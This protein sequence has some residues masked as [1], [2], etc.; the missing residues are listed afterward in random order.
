[1]TTSAGLRLLRDPG[2]PRRATFLELFFDLVFVVALALISH[3]L[4]DHF[5]LAGIAQA[6]VMLL[7]IWWVWSITTLVTDFYDPRRPMIQAVTIGTMFGVLLMA[8]AV[9]AA[10]TDRGL[11]FA[12]TYVAI[13]LGRGAL[14]VP[15][16]LGEPVRR[17]AA[18]VAFWFAVSAVPWLIGAFADGNVRLLW[19]SAALVIDYGASAFSYPVPVAGRLPTSQFRVTA[20]HLSERYQQFFILALGDIILVA[21]TTFSISGF[22]IGSAAAFTVA[23]ASAA[24]LWRIYVH[25]AGELLPEAIALSTESGRFARSAP[26]THVVMIAG[27]VATAASAKIT[28]THPTGDTQAGWIAIILGGPA[29]FLAGRARFESEVL[30]RTSRPLLV[31]LAGIAAVAPLMLLLPPVLIAV[32]ANLAL[33]GI[34]GHDIATGHRHPPVSAAPD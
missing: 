4:V 22:S 2:S 30:G 5:G 7:A 23:F 16:L 14:L 34:V 9:P 12:G 1:M 6:I 10:F 25:Q 13:H 26:Y 29:L 32:T 18:Q 19:W 24:L 3:T 21:G 27:V 31:G 28:I 33:I 15:A 11:I 20:E 17:R 8:A